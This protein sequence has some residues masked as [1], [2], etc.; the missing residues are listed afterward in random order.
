MKNGE[1]DVNPIKSNNDS[2]ISEENSDGNDSQISDQ[3]GMDGDFHREKRGDR[4]LVKMEKIVIL[5]F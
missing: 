1:D 3:D 2:Q 5:F 4:P